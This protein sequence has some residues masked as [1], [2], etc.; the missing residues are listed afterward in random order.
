LDAE[1]MKGTV[2]ALPTREDIPMPIQENLI[3][4]LYSK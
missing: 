3:V 2:R 4:E 1:N